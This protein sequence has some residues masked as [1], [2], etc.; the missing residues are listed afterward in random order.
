MALRLVPSLGSATGPYFCDAS[1]VLLGGGDHSGSTPGGVA[2]TSVSC[3]PRP[4]LTLGADR[5]AGSGHRPLPP[6]PEVS[7]SPE[8]KE[9]GQGKQTEDKRPVL[10]S[11]QEGAGGNRAYRGL[12]EECASDN[13]PGC[14]RKGQGAGSVAGPPFCRG[15]RACCGARSHR[16]GGSYQ[17]PH[18]LGQ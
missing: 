11:E 8:R 16:A 14:V 1:S 3:L 5:G 13:S 6:L 9:G 4:Q 18:L 2:L 7:G 15:D 12:V 17:P 10:G